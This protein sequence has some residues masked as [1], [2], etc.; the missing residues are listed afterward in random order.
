MTFKAI[1]SKTNSLSITSITA[2]QVLVNRKIKDCV[3]FGRGR[4]KPGVLLS[5]NDDLDGE[6]SYD[7]IRAFVKSLNPNWPTYV[8]M[9]DE[10]ILFANPER[11]FILTDKGTIN[12]RATLALYVTDIEEAYAR[13]LV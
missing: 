1:I 9:H 2:S 10:L 8:E 5:L 4:P 6:H 7:E 11:P 12:E 3:V 13:L